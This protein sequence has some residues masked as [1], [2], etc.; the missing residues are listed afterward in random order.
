MIMMMRGL[1]F[2]SES[3]MVCAVGAGQC[4]GRLRRNKQRRTQVNKADDEWINSS[5]G[6]I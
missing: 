1:R 5:N 3:E 6:D 2:E 4:S